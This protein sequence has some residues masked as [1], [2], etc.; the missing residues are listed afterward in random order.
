MATRKIGKY[1]TT[2]R[3]EAL[4]LLDGG[5]I[6]GNVV[7]NGQ[8]NMTA[9]SH[10]SGSG[11]FSNKIPVQSITA[12]KTLDGE[13]MI[14]FIFGDPNTPHSNKVTYGVR[15]KIINNFDSGTYFDSSLLKNILSVNKN[16]GEGLIKFSAMGMLHYVF[17]EGTC[18]TNYYMTSK[19]NV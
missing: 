14:N 15:S 8:V 18:T 6:T 7:V 12:D 1:K 9:I 10:V 11:I 17:N 4:T 2:K 5:T 3:E 13:D 19:E 16:C